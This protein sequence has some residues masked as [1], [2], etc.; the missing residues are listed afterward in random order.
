MSDVI[1]SHMDRW[2]GLIAGS[3]ELPEMTVRGMQAQGYR[4]ACVGMRGICD[5]KL[6]QISDK[7]SYA[8]ALHLGKWLRKLRGWGCGE[9]ILIGKFHKVNI[10]DPIQLIRM[11]LDWPT[12]S[13]WLKLKHNRG[14]GS[15][16]STLANTMQEKGVRLMDQTTFIPQAIADEGVMT[17][18]QPTEA[19]WADINY[20]WE[21]VKEISRLDIG[22]SLA[23][24]RGMVIAVEAIE[25][26]DRM[27][28]RAGELCRKGDWVMLKGA[29]EKH[30]M[31][32][33][34][35]TVGVRTIQHLREHGAKCL[36]LQAGKVIMA[37]KAKLIEQADQ[38]GI[39]VVGRA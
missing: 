30:D 25:G 35:P 16:L 24:N 15:I 28:Q 19:Q 26:T 3:G 6:R 18:I 14:D 27:I 9:A 31:R 33:D 11:G 1:M 36:V 34:V 21:K 7:F 38:A 32:I 5:P 12:I 13:I 17:K 29:H 22:Q 8:G 23:V 20:G 37:E 4:V 2:I 10:F 39:C